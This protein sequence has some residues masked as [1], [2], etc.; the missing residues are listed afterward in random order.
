MS[1]AQSTER[2]RWQRVANIINGREGFAPAVTQQVVRVLWDDARV[3][4]D[5]APR[6]LRVVNEPRP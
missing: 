2:F 4:E 3:T 5:V 6:L 1:L